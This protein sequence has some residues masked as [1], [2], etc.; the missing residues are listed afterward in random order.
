[1][2]TKDPLLIFV[3]PVGDAVKEI[4]RVVCVG[5]DAGYGENLSRRR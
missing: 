4:A 5:G 1:M 2:P 3:D